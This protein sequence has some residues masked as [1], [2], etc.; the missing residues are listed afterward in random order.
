MY[1]RRNDWN[2]KI[3]RGILTERDEDWRGCRSN[4]RRGTNFFLRVFVFVYE[5]R[6]S[7]APWA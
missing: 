6:S 5:L 2:A 4:Y 3:F 1:Q 7:D